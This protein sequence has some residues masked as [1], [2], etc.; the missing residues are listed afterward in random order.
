[1]LPTKAEKDER[2]SPPAAAVLPSLLVVAGLVLG[3]LYYGSAT[4]ITSFD[5]MLNGARQRRLGNSQADMTSRG[6]SPTVAGKVQGLKFETDVSPS[7]DSDVL[8]MQNSLVTSEKKIQG[9]KVE[10]SQVLS[11]DFLHETTAKIQTLTLDRQGKTRRLVTAI[12]EKINSLKLAAPDVE[13]VP[14]SSSMDIHIKSTEGVSTLE[15]GVKEKIENLNLDSGGQSPELKTLSSS[16]I[17]DKGDDYKLAM[18][19]GDCDNDE[20][21]A[22]DLICFDRSSG[23]TAPVPGCSGE[24]SAGRDY[25]TEPPPPTDA[26]SDA[27]SSV[28]TM[29]PTFAPT[30]PLPS[31]TIVQKPEVSGADG[32]PPLTN[33]D[34]DVR[35]ARDDGTYYLCEGDCDEDECSEGLLCYKR[36]GLAPVPGCSGQGESGDNYCVD[37]ASLAFL[38]LCEGSCERDEDCFGSLECYKGGGPR[39]PGCSGER[40]LDDSYCVEAGAAFRRPQGSFRLRLYWQQG[41][42]WQ[43]SSR[44]KW[45]CMECEGSCRTGNDIEIGYCDEDS[46][47]DSQDIWFENLN[48]DG[49]DG[50]SQLK[51]VGYDGLC[52][53]MS[54]SD[55]Q[56]VMVVENCDASDR[57]QFFKPSSSDAG[58]DGDRF[59]ITTS[60]RCISQEHHPKKNEDL[61][62]TSCSTARGDDTSYWEK[63]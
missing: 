5:V 40:D 45:Y 14:L 49:S 30:G 1:M 24:G 61:Y 35:R 18:C 23:S 52:V 15:L 17:S 32:D 50:T 25:C 33:V 41:Y 9:V 6:V 2:E 55:G 38:N 29:S 27:P 20:D 26:P 3:C 31:L 48:L 34:R 16:E 56:R 57:A 39:I 58:W 8:G 53:G 59:E 54:S 10:T 44:E 4:A 46:I 22:G 43:E 19:E 7:S 63:W 42:N 47:E 51:M 13:I 21:C 62:A 28:P 11:D 37:P 12:D 36:S 60:S